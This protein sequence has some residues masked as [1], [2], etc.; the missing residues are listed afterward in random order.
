MCSRGTCPELPPGCSDLELLAQLQHQGAATGL[1]DFTLDP[2]VALWFACV[3]HPESDGAVYVLPRSKVQEADAA[4]LRSR[5]LLDYFY[6]SNMRD[7]STKPHLW[8]PTPTRG[9]PAA[10]SAVFIFG[11][12]FLWPA[13]LGKATI[14]RSAKFNLLS[15]LRSEHGITEESLFVDFAGYA[16]ANSASKPYDLRRTTEF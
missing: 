5:S 4:A 1:I 3:G 12:P 13:F 11:V 15:E 10:Q 8:C 9:R 14:N 6:R 16:Q 2:L 7:W